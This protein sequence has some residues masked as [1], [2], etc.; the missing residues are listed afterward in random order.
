MISLPEGKGKKRGVRINVRVVSARGGRKKKEA[1]S[2]LNLLLK[3]REERRNLPL[4]SVIKQG[5]RGRKGQ[6]NH[7]KKGKR[8]KYYYSFRG[9]HE[10]R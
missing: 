5:G 4:P 8:E 3:R 1:W 10:R 9:K 7:A 2:L 6:K